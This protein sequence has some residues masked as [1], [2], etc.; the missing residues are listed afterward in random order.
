VQ[1]IKGAGAMLVRYLKCQ[2]M[3]LLCGGLVG[4]IFLAVFFAAG[5]DD[6]MKWMFWAGLVVTA[7]DVLIA[8]ALA[9]SGAKS[10]VKLQALEAN[11]LLALARVT[12]ITETGTQ[13]N[14]RPLVKLDLHIEGPGV[15]PF[16][17]ADRVIASIPRMSLITARYLAVLVDPATNEFQIDWQRS[18]LVAGTAPAQFRSDED[19]KTYD[20]TGRAEPIM[21][22]LRILKANQVPA[23]GTIDIRSNPAVRQQVMAVVRRATAAAEPVSAPSAAAPVAPTVAAPSAAQ[24]LQEL[25]TLR[26]MGTVTESEYTAKRAQIIAD[27]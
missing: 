26:V 8:L 14:N 13:I 17:A 21:E 1:L 5:Q 9:N 7:A 18:T 24:R 22:I 23:D 25:E 15:V 12:G 2:A 16:D 19:G 27:L 6:L 10:Q 11:G 3:V 20:L 4:P